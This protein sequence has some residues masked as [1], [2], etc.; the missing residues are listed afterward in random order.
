MS[1][2]VRV[3]VCVLHA[4]DF[5]SGRTERAHVNVL[6]LL[7][8]FVDVVIVVAV[9]RTVVVVDAIHTHSIVIEGASKCQDTS[10]RISQIVDYHMFENAT[11]N[12]ELWDHDGRQMDDL[13]DDRR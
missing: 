12:T 1:S 2:C 13:V 5:P 4:M 8:R 7:I 10:N 9:A 6:L 11:C 3:R